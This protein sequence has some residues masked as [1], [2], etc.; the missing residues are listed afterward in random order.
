MAKIGIP[1]TLAYFAYY[2]FCKVFFEELGHEVVLSSPTSRAILDDGVKE[3]VN[4]ACIPIKI[5]HGHVLDLADKV[6]WIFCPRLVSVR[7][8]GDFGTETF[9][10][11]FLGLPDMIRLAID[12]LPRLLE[13]RV[14][15]KKGKDELAQVFIQV[16]T[17]LGNGLGEIKKALARAVK[18][19]KNYRKLLSREILP[20]VALEML[21]QQAERPPRDVEYDLKIA[22]VGYPYAIYDAY[23]NAGLLKILEK[24]GA[25]VYTQDMLSDK[26]LDRQA[27]TLPKSMFWYF[28]NRAV[29]GGLHFMN[30]QDID[31]IIHV[32][33]FACGPDSMVDR[34][35]EIESRRHHATPYLS[36]TVDEHTGEAGVRTRIEAFLDMLRYRR[37]K[38]YEN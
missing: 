15:L 16:G 27:R 10:P 26:E 34:L 31:G 21:E 7:K 29:Y 3:A 23:I 4:D 12:K 22:V 28:S 1:R 18:A 20:H 5:Y 8:H 37:E 32:T 38:I 17:Q 25:K 13:V 14:D 30:R 9:C 24:E 19:Q 11:K 36:I 2:P 35:L 6:D 33:A